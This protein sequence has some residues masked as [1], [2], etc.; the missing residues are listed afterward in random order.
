MCV[1]CVCR[2][3]QRVPQ[4]QGSNVKK[5]KK[6]YIYVY[7]SKV[8]IHYYFIFLQ[9]VT[10]GHQDCI[11]LIKILIYFKRILCNADLLSMLETCDTFFRIL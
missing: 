4:G 5:N 3:V 9:E 8:W 6:L 1:V 2:D 7:R 10:Y 11:Y